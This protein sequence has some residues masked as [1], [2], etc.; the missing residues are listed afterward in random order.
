[1]VSGQ[2]SLAGR[3]AAYCCLWQAEEYHHDHWHGWKVPKIACWF[4]HFFLCLD[5]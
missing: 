4:P 1:M 2:I 3:S 5:L